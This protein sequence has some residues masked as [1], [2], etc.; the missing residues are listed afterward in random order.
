MKGGCLMGNKDIVQ[1]GDRA[2]KMY[3]YPITHSS[4]CITKHTPQKKSKKPKN[5]GWIPTTLIGW[6]T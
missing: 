3:V 5:Q 1:G 6:E 2:Y 4:K